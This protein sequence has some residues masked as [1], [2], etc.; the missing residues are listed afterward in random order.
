[1]VD[2]IDEYGEEEEVVIGRKTV[3]F[4]TNNWLKMTKA[5]VPMNVFYTHDLEVA[6][7]KTE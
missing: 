6:V 5:K 7:Q 3:E 1:M 2:T 4:S